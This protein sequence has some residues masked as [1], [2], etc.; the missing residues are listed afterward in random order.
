MQRERSFL[1][2]LIVAGF[3]RMR[4]Q[5]VAKCQVPIDLGRAAFENM[6]ME[7]LAGRSVF[8]RAVAPAWNPILA[9]PL[10]APFLQGGRACIQCFETA[11]L[12]HEVDHRLRLD[13]GYGCRSDMMNFQQIVA[14]N[15]GKPLCLGRGDTLPGAILR[16]KFDS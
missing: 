1:F 2:G 14:K 6:H 5:I 3:D 10:V 7:P 13:S 4:S 9:V 12:R 16:T 8:T 11:D 15:I